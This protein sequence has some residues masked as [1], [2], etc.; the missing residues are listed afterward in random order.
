[1]E[2]E[3]KQQGLI[4]QQLATRDDVENARRRTFS[5]AQSTLEIA[6]ARSAPSSRGEI[7]TAPFDGVVTAISVSTRR[8]DLGGGAADDSLS[9]PPTRSS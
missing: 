2:Q 9:P 4:K 3:R 1:M 8:P 5:D 6:R 7:L